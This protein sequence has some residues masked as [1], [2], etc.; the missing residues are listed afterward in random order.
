MKLQYSS[1]IILA[2]LI[3]NSHCASDLIIQKLNSNWQFRQEDS[4]KFY[5]ASVP[6]TVHTDLMNNKLIDD[7][8]YRD[9]INSVQWVENT[10][11]IYTTRFNLANPNILLSNRI[12]L[13][14]EGLDTHATVVLNNQIILKADN[15]FRTW[16]VNVKDFIKSSDNNLTIIFTPANFYDQEQI[17]KLKP[18][19][20]PSDFDSG[21]VFTRKAA[22]HFGWD[23]GPRLI[24]AGIW[25]PAYLQA[26]NLTKIEYIR[27][28]KITIGDNIADISTSI[29]LNVNIQAECEVKLFNSKTQEVYKNFKV[30]LLPGDQSSVAFQFS[31]KN[32]KLW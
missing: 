9:N 29:D 24:T 20:L 6:G 11:W 30:T 26:W 23:W 28:Q 3:L 14:F 5:G 22:Y 17:N 12:D 31:I 15:M 19:V 21:R 4:F 18:L 7:P 25:R 32:P 8:Y 16:V 1:L 27:F 10:T 13:V 2:L